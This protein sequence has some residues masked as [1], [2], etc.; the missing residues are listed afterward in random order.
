MSRDSRNTTTTHARIRWLEARPAGLERDVG[1]RERPA[2]EE[3]ARVAELERELARAA[4]RVSAGAARCEA[5]DGQLARQDAERRS[6]EAWQQEQLEDAI[7]RKTAAEMRAGCGL[8]ERRPGSGHKR[9][10]AVRWGLAT[11]AGI[12][13][14]W[15]VLV[16]LVAILVVLGLLTVLAGG[17]R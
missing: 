12:A 6:L 4:G 3:A 2:R 14:V 1:G 16:H 10:R 8:V 9:M 15:R 11:L 7:H 13:V 17:R 5:L